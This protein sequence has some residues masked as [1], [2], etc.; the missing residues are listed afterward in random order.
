MYPSLVECSARFFAPR[1]HRIGYTHPDLPSQLHVQPARA[2]CF[3]VVNFLISKK[4]KGVKEGTGREP[5][6]GA[7]LREVG[8]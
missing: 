2:L 3:A 1:H 7:Y 6:K 4:E 8:K 5:K